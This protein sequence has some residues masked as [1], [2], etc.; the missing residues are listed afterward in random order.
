MVGAV[1]VGPGS[2]APSL[3]KILSELL[4]ENIDDGDCEVGFCL[5]SGIFKQGGE[6]LGLVSS[7]AYFIVGR[8]IDGL[9]KALDGGEVVCCPVAFASVHSC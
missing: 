8:E 2:I 1:D 7:R 3:G 9:S 4:S 6:I 5:G